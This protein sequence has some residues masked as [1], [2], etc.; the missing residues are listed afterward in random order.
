M[1]DTVETRL[2]PLRERWDDVTNPID[3][4][5]VVSILTWAWSQTELQDAIRG[6]YRLSGTADL[7]PFRDP[8]FALVR[9]WLAGSSYQAMAGSANLP[10][11][12]LL[13]VHTRVV[14]FVLQTLVEQGIS[15]LEK[16]LIS[17]EGTLS[18]AAIQFPDHLRFGV[19]TESA[20]LFAA[21]GVRHRRA[22]VELGAAI[23]APTGLVL[24]TAS[25]FRDAREFLR[26][27]AAEWEPRL[28]RLVYTNTLQDLA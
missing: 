7:E 16:L 25:F 2:L 8:F 23:P 10:V 26:D 15:L 19:P 18:R 21:K 22:A 17:R 3:A 14:T 20:V 28:G 12:E 1:I 5:L 6:A 24:E 9:A 4:S 13:G 27:Q 11:D